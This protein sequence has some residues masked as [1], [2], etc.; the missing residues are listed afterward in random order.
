M[1]AAQLLPKKLKKKREMGPTQGD[2]LHTAQPPWTDIAHNNQY[3]QYM[4]IN[5]IP[6]TN[7]Y[8][9]HAQKLQHQWS[10][11]SLVDETSWSGAQKGN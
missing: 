7:N 2:I 11:R 4:E 1:N 6:H 3:C 8:N 10:P 9:N 5:L